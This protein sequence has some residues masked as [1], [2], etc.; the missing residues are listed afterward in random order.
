MTCDK[1]AQVIGLGQFYIEARKREGKPF[2]A[3][4]PGLD[5]GLNL[6][7]YVYLHIPTCDVYP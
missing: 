6:D 7:P 4:R 3:P 5:N 1:C 2:I